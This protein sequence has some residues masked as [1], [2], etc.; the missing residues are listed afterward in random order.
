M[1]VNGSGNVVFY[2][3]DSTSVYGVTGQVL[4]MNGSGVP[5]FGHIDCGTY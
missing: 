2:N 3:E 1:G 5:S 4:Q